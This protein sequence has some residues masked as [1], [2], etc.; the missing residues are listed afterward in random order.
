[1]LAL[2][3]RSTKPAPSSDPELAEGFHRVRSALRAGDAPEVER[4]LYAL[5][6]GVGARVAELRSQADAVADAN[7]RAVEIHEQH[8]E[9]AAR[10]EAQNVELE[11]QTKLLARAREELAAQSRAVAEANVEAVFMLDEHT[12]TVASLKRD[13]TELQ[14]TKATLEHKLDDLEQQA[15]ALAESNAEAVA[16][17]E[18]AHEA[19]AELDGHAKRV[20]EENEVLQEK[21]FVDGLT[22]LLNHRYLKEQIDIEIARAERYG[23]PLSVVFLDVD[24]FKHLNDTHGHST[25]D[26]V[27]RQIA[28]VLRSE[29]RGADVPIR[30]TGVPFA[31]RYGGEEFV[32]ILP[33]TDCDGARVVAERLRSS[34]EHTDL[35][36]GHTQPL[37]RITLSAGV[38]TRDAGETA[39]KLLERADEALYGAKRAGR[40]RVESC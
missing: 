18:S 38:A 7:A 26:A 31:V 37:G 20:E 39:A 5:E 1:M 25:G 33:E 24:H 19:I 12:E 22:G 15:E 23:R 10:L 9:L 40:N 28:D 3:T 16:L 21:A 4:A 11:R 36:G 13:R 8:V 17:M 29:I 30:M 35:P 2:N 32:I 27:L 14:G 34:I 6:L